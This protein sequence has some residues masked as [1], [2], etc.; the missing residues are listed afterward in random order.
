MK[1]YVKWNDPYMSEKHKCI[2]FGDTVAF[3]FYHTMKTDIATL[4]HVCSHIV[5]VNHSNPHGYPQGATKTVN[6]SAS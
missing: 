4:I 6:E 5:F 3:T 1:I 2:Y